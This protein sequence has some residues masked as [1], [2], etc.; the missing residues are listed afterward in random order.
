MP[1]TTPILP[2][3]TIR[4]LLEQQIDI[5]AAIEAAE[6]D[7]ALMHLHAM[8]YDVAHQITHWLVEAEAVTHA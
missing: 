1:N 5:L 4:A 3:D 8:Q 7:D 6:D 2:E